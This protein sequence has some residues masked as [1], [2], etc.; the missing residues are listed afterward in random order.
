MNY[1]VPWVQMPW[2]KELGEMPSVVFSV[3]EASNTV[4]WSQPLLGGQISHLVSFSNDAP[5]GSMGAP[6]IPEKV[7]LRLLCHALT[8]WMPDEAL[9]ELGETMG[10]MFQFY[11]DREVEQDVVH[12]LTH[13]ANYD[14]E[15]LEP[16]T[17]PLF[18]IA[19]E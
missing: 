2:N 7:C 15:V 8:N 19:G 4:R 14:V 3:D 6:Q 18:Q 17:R 10:E 16:V 11:R 5:T 9:P 1:T 13:F 12:R